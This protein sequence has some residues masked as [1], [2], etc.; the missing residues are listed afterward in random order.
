[1]GISSSPCNPGLE[2]TSPRLGARPFPSSYS[3]LEKGFCC[4]GV[5]SL[6]GHAE[7]YERGVRRVRPPIVEKGSRPSRIPAQKPCF[8]VLPRA[9]PWELLSE[10][11]WLHLRSL[12]HQSHQ[13]FPLGAAKQCSGG[14]S[15]L[16][17]LSTTWVVLRPVVLG[18]E[19]GAS[20]VP[21]RAPERSPQ[22]F[23]KS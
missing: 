12:R 10:Q 20:H 9:G 23:L 22:L 3:G 21:G 4:P 15:P 11:E 7:Q 18:P 16:Q 6:P 5:G 19:L 2:S 8:V 13:V 17:A 14:P 1:M